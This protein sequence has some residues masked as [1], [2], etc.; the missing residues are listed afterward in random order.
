MT[1]QD[2]GT[3][4][5]LV[6][7]IATVATLIYLA[8]QI[9]Q[10]TN[11]MK[12]AAVSSLHDVQLLTRDNDRY[13]VLILKSLRSEELTPEERLHMVERFFTIVRA[14]EGIWLQQRLG[15]VTQDQFDQHLDLL[16]WAI[17]APS[18]RRM[19]E[20]LAPTFAPGFRAVVESE[21]LS[22]DAPPSRMYKALSALDPEWVDRG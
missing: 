19:W 16:R 3:I 10:N 6:A 18:A 8:A 7:A 5:E 14:F 2:L 13:N 4:G 11:S 9:R 22:A 21:V 12:T 15:A 20:Q 1:I 17:S